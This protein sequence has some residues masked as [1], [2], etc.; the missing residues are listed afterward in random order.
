M[1]KILEKFCLALFVPAVLFMFFFVYEPFDYW[2][3]KGWTIYTAKPISAMRE[4]RV[5]GDGDYLL[6][7]DSRM[8]NLNTD[9]VSEA[10]G[11]DYISLAFGGGTLSENYEQL[12][13][14]FEDLGI[15]P[16]KVVMGLN[17]YTACPNH[18]ADRIYETE[19]KVEKLREF[20][21]VPDYWYYALRQFEVKISEELADLTG[22]ESIR[23]VLEDPTDPN[24]NTEPTMTEYKNDYRYDILAYSDTITAQIGD[25]GDISVTLEI[26]NRMIDLCESHGTKIEF[27][28]WPSNRCMFDRVIGAMGLE[29]EIEAYKD[30]LKSRCVVCETTRLSAISFA[31]LHLEKQRQRCCKSAAASAKE[32][33]RSFAVWVITGNFSGLHP[34]VS[35]A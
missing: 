5:R 33:S 31:L 28:L 29:D 1:R 21:S 34:E 15:V 24:Q 23:R 8:A 32:W 7:G 26:L 12:R 16:E 14:V 25:Y 6:V 18:S 35:S 2:A 11:V 22:I 17:F 4:L 10:A 30:L 19:E 27:I 13:Y 3:V 20:I 9:M